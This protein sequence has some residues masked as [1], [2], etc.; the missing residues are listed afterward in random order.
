MERCINRTLIPLGLLGLTLALAF[1]F[2]I[3]ILGRGIASAAPNAQTP[4]AKSPSSSGL[5]ASPSTSK[6]AE[7]KLMD[8]FIARFTSRLGIDETKLNTAFS[9]AV[10]ETVD[11]AVHDGTLT[12]DQ[13]NE[14]KDVAGKGFR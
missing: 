5:P 7:D 2:G 3:G 9:A 13:A 12:Q 14:A 10:N 8:T 6:S 11:A 1:G 4:P